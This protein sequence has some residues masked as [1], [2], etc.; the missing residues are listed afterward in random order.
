[1]ATWLPLA[2]IASK[3][4]SKYLPWLTDP[5]SMTAGLRR[6]G[7]QI[8]VQLLRQAR[9]C[10]SDDEARYLGLDRQEYP[11]IREVYLHHHGVIWVYARSLIPNSLLTGPYRQVGDQLDQRPLGELLFSQAGVCRQQIEITCLDRSH[12]EFLQAIQA[13]PCQSDQLWARRSLFYVFETCLSVSE[14]IFPEI[15]AYVEA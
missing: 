12:P 7:G 15:L 6:A 14:I 3:I 9:Q 10:P 11:L 8:H 1:M 13:N 2:Q 4:P 5:Y